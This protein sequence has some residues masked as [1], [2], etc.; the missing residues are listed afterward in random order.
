MK[1]LKK[2]IPVS[3]SELF[4]RLTVSQI[5]ELFDEK[6]RQSHSDELLKIEKAIDGFFKSHPVAMNAYFIRLIIILAQ[7]NIHIWR[8]KEAMQSGEKFY[9]NTKLAHQLNGVRNKVKNLILQEANSNLG[10]KKS[11]TDTEALDFWNVSILDGKESFNRLLGEIDQRSIFS[12]DDSLNFTLTDLIDEATISQIKEALFTGDA[13]KTSRN[14]LCELSYDINTI[15]NE[16]R[17][18]SGRLMRYIILLAQINFYVWFNKDRM[19]QEPEQ[20]DK[21]LEQAQDLNSLRNHVRN[22]LMDE[23]QEGSPAIMKSSFLDFEGNNNWYSATINSL[24]VGRGAE[25]TFSLNEGDFAKMFGIKIEELPSSALKIIR[26]KDFRYEKLKGAQRDEILL[27]VVKR[28][29]SGNFWVSGQDKKDIW[30]KGWSENLA[31]YNKTLASEGLIP[32]FIQSHPALRLNGEYIRPLESDFEFNF[33]DVYR[34]WAFQT[35]FSDVKAIYEFGCGSGQHLVSLAEVFKGRE[36][37][38]L[39]WA[40]SSSKII[41]ALNKDRGW[42]IEA[43][44]FDMFNPDEKVGFDKPSAV[45]TVGTMEQMGK[46][47]EPFLQY[48][49]KNKPAIVVHMETIEEFYDDSNFFDYLAHVYDNARNYL[50]GYLTRLK[51]LEKEGKITIIKAQHIPFGSMYHDSYSFVAWKPK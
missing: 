37:H 28:I 29:I 47:F 23:F 50:S 6:N 32:K 24:G 1:N 9:E 5:K 31:T 11:N 10:A 15:L 12:T 51:Q 7:I 8:T 46:N 39:D 22:I 17:A 19:Q 33:A 26:E 13:K 16:E 18:L 36:L 20:Y 3:I 27:T 43:H 49:L 42:N 25:S 4:D 21:L 2:I 14:R 48:L 30:E 40:E 35:F 41:S 44:V 45:F 34:Q 38:G